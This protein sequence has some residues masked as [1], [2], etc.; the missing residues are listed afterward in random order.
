MSRLFVCMVLA[1]ASIGFF[2]GCNSNERSLLE[3]NTYG[4]NGDLKE[5]RETRWRKERVERE[6]VSVRERV[7][8]E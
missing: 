3:E 4:P 7:V 2:N 1:C 8:R 5:R 6:P